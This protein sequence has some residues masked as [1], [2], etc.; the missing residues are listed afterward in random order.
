M[1]HAKH[2][3]AITTIIFSLI[4]TAVTG[5]TG[6]LDSARIAD[7]MKYQNGVEFMKINDYSRALNEFNEYLE[8]YINGMHRGKAYR[9]IAEI[10]ISR[11][12][13]Q[14]A[15][16]AYMGIYQEYSY[17]EEG[18]D[19]YFQAGVSYK[20]MGYDRKAGDIFRHIVEEHP[21]TS[22]AYNAGIQL[23]LIKIIAN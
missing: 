23:E 15:I 5:E 13:F 16:K 22:A 4:T 14:R 20:K 3:A 11:F 7:N 21:G 17:T 9:N 1:I 18:I 2:L 12:D 19:A 6:A 10:H 8:I